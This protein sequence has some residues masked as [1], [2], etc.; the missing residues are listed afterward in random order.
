[1]NVNSAA[2]CR[3]KRGIGAVLLFYIWDMNTIVFAGSFM[4]TTRDE[5]WMTTCVYE[6]CLILWDLINDKMCVIYIFWNMASRLI[7]NNLRCV[8][9]R[10]F[11]N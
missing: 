2:C 5:E 4:T 7:L 10:Q 11:V 6:H 3:D 8:C 9:I 1:M